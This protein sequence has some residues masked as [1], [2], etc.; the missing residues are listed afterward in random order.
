M[1]AVVGR[2]ACIEVKAVGL[3][4]PV[5]THAQEP[6]PGQ[7]KVPKAPHVARGERAFAIRVAVFVD[8]QNRLVRAIE[9]KLNIGIEDELDRPSDALRGLSIGRVRFGIR[10]AVDG[11][12][13]FGLP[14]VFVSGFDLEP[15]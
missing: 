9:T 1:G 8:Q 3:R 12:L 7:T 11:L 2:R 13:G 15:T 10:R 5:G 14:L 6:Q 4:G